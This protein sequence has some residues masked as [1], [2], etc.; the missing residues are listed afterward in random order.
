VPRPHQ[1]CV[2]LY[3][4]DLRNDDQS[5]TPSLELI[6]KFVDVLDLIDA[7]ALL[8]VYNIQQKFLL[9]KG[10]LCV[11]AEKVTQK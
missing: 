5:H 9:V 1:A 2:L 4:S 10:L 11:P 7:D 6:A 3:D 8:N